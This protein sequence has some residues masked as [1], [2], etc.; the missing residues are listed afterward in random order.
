MVCTDEQG[1]AMTGRVRVTVVVP[2]YNHSEYL[3]ECLASVVGQSMENWEAVVV[4]DG[5]TTGD[6]PAI[7][8]A[9]G[10]ERIRTVRHEQNQGLAAAR[11]TGIREGRGEYVLPLDADDKLAPEFLAEALAALNAAHCDAVFTD[12][13]AFGVRSGRLPY[14][15]DDVKALL[16][17][18]WIPGPGTL[19]KRTLWEKAGGYCEADALRPGNEDWDFWLSAAEQG[20]RVTHVPRPLYWYR[21]HVQSMVTRLQYHDYLT[22]VFIYERHRALFDQYGMGNVF[23]S[24]GYLSSAKAH[25]RRRERRRALRLG[26]QSFLLAPGECVRSIS[27]QTRR[28]LRTQW[29]E[30]RVSVVT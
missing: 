28:W 30:Q 9:I 26:A 19:C 18:Q 25:W 2:V 8:R 23:L 20:L 4:D 13:M 12:F 16:K 14:Q 15:V 5:S 24:G 7:V 21:Q 27:A 22:R 10:D 3:A 17:D 6:I 29:T 1:V 11:N